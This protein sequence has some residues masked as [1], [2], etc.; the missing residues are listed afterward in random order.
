[1]QKPSYFIRKK[2]REIT[3]SVVFFSSAQTRIRGQMASTFQNFHSSRP[4]RICTRFPD[5]TSVRGTNPRILGA[6][7]AAFQKKDPAKTPKLEG[8]GE[9][10][11]HC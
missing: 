3:K 9:K 6:N 5:D 7:R 10:E 8:M 4:A 1:M 2:N 11:G